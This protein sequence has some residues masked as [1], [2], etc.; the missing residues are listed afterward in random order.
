MKKLS[1]LALVI[2]GLVACSKEETPAPGTGGGGNNGGGNNTT[3]SW[4]DTISRKWIVY[5]AFHNGSADHSSA[6]LIL[7][8]KPDGSYIL[9]NNG[10]NGT[11]EFT[12]DFSQALI[13]KNEPSY[14]TTWTFVTLSSSVMKI[15][16]KSPFTGGNVE[17]ELRPKK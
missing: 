10:Y 4:T 8:M 6:G 17:W 12:S 11:W 9:V 5:E 16:F 7:D 3:V 15:K 2:L 14:K 13:D 1:L